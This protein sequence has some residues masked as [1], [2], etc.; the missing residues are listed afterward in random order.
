MKGIM[1][2]VTGLIMLPVLAMA[3]TIHV[4]TE[5]PTILSGIIAAIDGDAADELGPLCSYPQDRYAPGHADLCVSGSRRSSNW[6]VVIRESGSGMANTGWG[7]RFF[8]HTAR[9]EDV[10][11][12]NNVV[13]TKTLYQFTGPNPEIWVTKK[14]SNTIAL[15]AVAKY[16]HISMML[17]DD[18]RLSFLEWDKQLHASLHFYQVGLRIQLHSFP[19]TPYVG[20][21]GGI[22]RGSLETFHH[23]TIPDADSGAFLASGNGGGPFLGVSTGITLP[24]YHGARA[25]IECG[26]WQDLGWKDF[27]VSSVHGVFGEH[28]SA[29]VHEDRD[30]AFS[31]FHI[32]LGIEMRL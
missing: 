18:V 29:F 14:I 20:I 2:L 25:F 10:R 27:E 22:C 1:A 21:D 26:Y 28:F 4:P 32:T 12:G 17:D 6:G 8:F 23:I 7:Y 16:Q 30:L 3:A 19:C 11:S 13:K 15:A 31:V 9:W 5:Q 24:L